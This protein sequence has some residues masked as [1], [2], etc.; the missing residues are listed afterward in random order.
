MHK[1][2]DFVDINN[3]N[4][5][6]P[7]LK[8]K[9]DH[10]HNETG[11]FRYKINNLQKKL[12]DSKYLVQ[13]NPDRGCKRRMPEQIESIC[14][15][16]NRNEFNFTKVSPKEIIFYITD[17][18]DKHALLVNVSPLSHYH[19]LLCPS[20][21]KCLPQ[22]VTLQSLQLAIE[23]YFIA[24]DRDLRI[25]FNSLC[26]LASVN[27]LH[28]HLFLEEHHLPVESVKCIHLINH[29]YYFNDYPIPGF[30]F[31]IP[32]QDSATKI[33]NEIYKLLEYFLKKSIAHNIFMTRG[34]TIIPG[35]HDSKDILRIFIWPRKS[36]AVKQLNSLN[37]AAC[38]I[39]GWFTIYNAEDYDRLQKEDLEC[40]LEKCKINDF[41]EL[42]NE[43]KH[44][45]IN[46]Q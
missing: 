36:S 33:T 6:I 1:L 16:F 11:V 22:I 32:D 14:Q 29:I 44:L 38:E 35:S 31:E 12:I 42:C 27:H 41:K 19:T 8:Q 3:T 18:S 10:L 26:A 23:I 46:I 9:W 7:T 21:N 45:D 20:I 2:S 15:P 34:Q 4:K 17:E 39:S 40:E 24:Q 30:C 5:F 37:I 13:L 25:A 43:I 28:Y